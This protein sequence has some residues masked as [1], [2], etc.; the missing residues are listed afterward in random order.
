[1]RRVLD[2]ALTGHSS[3]QRI[4]STQHL[5]LLPPVP[6]R[7]LN[8][9][10]PPPSPRLQLTRKRSLVE[11]AQ[12]LPSSFEEVKEGSL[13]PG[14]VASVTGD[15]VFVRFLGAVTGRAG[16]AALADTFVSD[17]RLHFSVGQSVVSKV[18]QVR[19][20]HGHKGVCVCVC[21][22]SAPDP[23]FLVPLCCALGWQAF[24]IEHVTQCSL[25]PVLPHP[26]VDADRRRFALTLKP[27]ALAAA[28]SG[29]AASA[30]SR[31]AAAHLGGLLRDLDAAHALTGAVAA[32]VPGSERAIDY[33]PFP[34]GGLVSGCIIIVTPPI[35]A[36][37]SLPM[38]ALCTGR[39]DKLMR[40]GAVA[41]GH[42][43]AAFA[44]A[45]G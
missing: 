36:V 39:A 4:N 45:H 16:L 42:Q 34:I 19:V 32:A 37:S 24:H 7:P 30:A 22:E 14:Y 41:A 13:L 26:Q 15:A 5:H 25:A 21:L 1:M 6:K 12:Q 28:A 43:V 31:A 17:P 35:E 44:G 8:M 27:S 3:C 2:L 33:S 23:C 29:S 40:S 10:V 38:H 11:A 20:G 9:F 18:V